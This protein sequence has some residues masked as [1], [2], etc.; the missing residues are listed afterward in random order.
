MHERFKTLIDDMYDRREEQLLS[1]VT[2]G[3]LD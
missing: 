1:A 3:A 2:A